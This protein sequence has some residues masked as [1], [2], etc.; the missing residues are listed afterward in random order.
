MSD[1]ELDDLFTTALTT[2]P[3]QAQPM[4]Y[5]Q[6]VIL[7]WNRVTLQNTVRVGGATFTDLPVLGLG[8]SATY[9]PGDVVGVMCVGSTWAIIGQLALPNTPAAAS[10]LSA[11]AAFINTASVFPVDNITSASFGDLAHVGPTV[12]ASIGPSGCALVLLTASLNFN[13]A[14]GG[15]AMGVD[16][17][18]ATTL[19]PNTAEALTYIKSGTLV[20][21]N[22]ILGGRSTA[23]VWF[24]GTLTPGSN[25]FTAKYLITVSGGIA[26]GQAG[27]RNIVV[28]PL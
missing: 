1:D 21:A 25:T 11:L 27:D 12:T 15:V 6:G 7:T 16:V 10:A 19:A 28:I 26:Q 5:R 17:S 24:N 18:G 9:D 13:E 14:A 8:E 3:G 2:P 4:T 22:M 20:A 23:A